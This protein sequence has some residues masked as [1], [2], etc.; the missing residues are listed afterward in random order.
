MMTIQCETARFRKRGTF[1]CRWCNYVVPLPDGLSAVL[2]V[3]PARSVVI[4]APTGVVLHDCND[5]VAPLDGVNPTSAS[6]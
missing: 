1:A 3:L 4:D 6:V 2:L 5:F